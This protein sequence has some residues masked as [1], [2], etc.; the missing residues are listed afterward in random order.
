MNRETGS[1]LNKSTR[2]FKFFWMAEPGHPREVGVLHDR[3]PAAG[4]HEAFAKKI[5][6]SLPSH[7]KLFDEGFNAGKALPWLT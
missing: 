5:R 1:G 3:P 4:T 7:R 6:I 2:K